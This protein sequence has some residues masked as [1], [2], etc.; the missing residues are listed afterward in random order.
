[1]TAIAIAMLGIVLVATVVLGIVG[2]VHE[3]TRSA[4]GR[5]WVRRRRYAMQVRADA[6]RGLT[7]H[8]LRVSRR[9]LAEQLAQPAPVH[10]PQPAL[11]VRRFAAH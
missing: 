10:V 3:L 4:R 5:R 6:F 2:A 8:G 9:A 11:R 7:A 1:M